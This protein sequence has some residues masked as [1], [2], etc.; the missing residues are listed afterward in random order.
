MFSN[1]FIGRSETSGLWGNQI[2]Q[3]EGGLKHTTG[4]SSDLF[5]GSIN[6]EFVYSKLFRLYVEG[7]CSR[8]QLG[9]G[10]GLVMTLIRDKFNIYLPLYT[11][12]GL[13]QFHNLNF[14]TYSIN[15]N[16]EDLF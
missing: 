12:S 2:V 11:E 5:I 4:V 3:A 9:Y 14:I 1:S 7:G 10:A 6:V 8:S 16:I 13:V 15:L